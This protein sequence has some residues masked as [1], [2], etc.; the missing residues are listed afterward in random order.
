MDALP[1][2]LSCETQA[3]LAVIAVSLLVRIAL[4]CVMGFSFDETYDIVV[5][6]KLALAYY[7]HPPAIMWLIHAVV[8]LTGSEDH[9]IVRLPTLLLFEDDMQRRQ[10]LHAKLL[11]AQARRGLGEKDKAIQLL[12][13]ILR[14]DPSQ[15]PAADLLATLERDAAVAEKKRI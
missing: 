12:H 1:S 15:A 4:A 8:A 5:A 2:A 9:L 6:R 7:D 10:T 11:T 3:V 13:D 14:D